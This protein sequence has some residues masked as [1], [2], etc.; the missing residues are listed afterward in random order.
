[1]TRTPSHPPP[2]HRLLVI[3]KGL[4]YH[5]DP[6]TE[7]RYTLLSATLGGTIV[8]T[9]EDREL[10]GTRVGN[11]RLRGCRIP[12][13]MRRSKLLAN[14]YYTLYLL[15]TT[16]TD[17]YFRQR[18]DVIVARE[19]I[20]AGPLGVLLKWLTG[21]RLIVELNGNYAS[22]LIWEEEEP[23][24]TT[25]LKRKY[26]DLIVPLVLGRADATKVLYDDQLAAYRSRL[27]LKR[28]PVRFHDYSMIDDLK[29]ATGHDN[30]ILFLGY[31]WFIKGVDVLIRA[32][33]TLASEF[34]ETEL[35]LVGYFPEPG[36]SMLQKLAEGVPTIHIQKAVYFDEAMELLS[37][38]R[39]F[40]LPSRT[41]GMGR[42]L[43]EAMA[44][45]KPII[46]SRVDGIPTYVIDGYNG[47]LFDSEDE[48]A[49]AGQIRTVLTDPKLAEK[50]AENGLRHVH[51]NL[52]GAMY[53]Q[54][55][56]ELVTLVCKNRQA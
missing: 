12:P 47:L 9:V 54:H 22:P 34:P 36:L 35:R 21:A 53:A 6:V 37:R 31:P 25:R 15:F 48:A 11:F 2:R 55:Y 1:M 50:L 44:H 46:A 10:S 27:R 19:P 39:V 29:P 24:L 42:V 28:P 43:L 14:L 38:C 51:Q 7:K 45:K 33:R 23:T 16:L 4:L 8:H 30:Y 3:S 40:V 26:C 18:Y 56:D 41:E 20:A 52:S 13:F 32:F 49:L 17:H 5:L